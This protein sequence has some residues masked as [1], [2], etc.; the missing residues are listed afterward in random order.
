MENLTR[1]NRFGFVNAAKTR[2]GCT[3]HPVRWTET[4]ISLYCSARC[5]GRFLEAT[6]DK[7]RD[8]NGHVA[9]FG[10]GVE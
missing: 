9:L 8:G 10:Q 7:M 3:T 2:E 4:R 1:I 5:G 6:S